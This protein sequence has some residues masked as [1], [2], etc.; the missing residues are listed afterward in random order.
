M[1]LSIKP[2]VLNENCCQTALFDIAQRMG[3]TLQETATLYGKL[4]QAV[5]MLGGE[6][7]DALSMVLSH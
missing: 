1:L 5:R 7:K 3:V 6:Q 4:Q 2:W